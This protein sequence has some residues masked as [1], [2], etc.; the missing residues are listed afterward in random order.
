MHNQNLQHECKVYFI[1]LFIIL[2]KKNYFK[3]AI[4][5]H[6]NIW[7]NILSKVYL[8]REQKLGDEVPRECGTRAYVATKS[9]TAKAGTIWWLWTYSRVPQR[10]R[11]DSP[12]SVL[13]GKKVCSLGP[14]WLW[15]YSRVPQRIRCDS[16]CSVLLGKKVCSLGL[17]WQ[18]S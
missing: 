7:R 16:P 3:F 4:H 15:T 9:A 1:H 12:C 18:W 17:A 5:T 14:A 13:L 8:W 10:V 11:S 2:F 6:K